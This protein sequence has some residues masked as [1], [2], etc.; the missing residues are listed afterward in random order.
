MATLQ[1]QDMSCMVCPFGGVR[2]E[3]LDQFLSQTFISLVTSERKKKKERKRGFFC[4]QITKFSVS[5]PQP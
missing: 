3:C 4:L 5:A 2:S 1:V